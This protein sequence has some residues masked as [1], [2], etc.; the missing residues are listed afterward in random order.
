MPVDATTFA[1]AL[2]SA[3]SSSLL[4]GMCGSLLAT[5]EMA[6]PAAPD[7]DGDEVIV[8]VLW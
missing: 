4:S 2:I 1:S 5:A 7:W 6:E 3:L 8:V